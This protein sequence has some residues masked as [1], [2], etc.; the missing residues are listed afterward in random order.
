[1]SKKFEVVIVGG[2]TAGLSVAARLRNA[3]NPPEVAII[4]PSDKHYYQ[5][6]WTL[7]GAGVFPREITE[8]EEADYIP[9]GATWIRDAVASFDPEQNALTTKKG[10]VIQYDYLVVAAGIQLNWDK[11]D[12]LKEALGKNGVCSN[13]SYATVESTWETIRGF[14]GGKALFTFPATPIKCAG[15]PQKIMYLAEHAF[16]RQ[17]VRADS[18]LVYCC[19]GP[20][21]FGVAK[22][23]D[24]LEKVVADRDIKTAFRHNLEAIRADKKQAVFRDL[25]KDEQVVMDYEMIHV[26]PPQGAPAFIA[27]SKLASE[28]GWVEVD[29]HSL[30]HVRY[31]NVFSLGDC[32]SLPCSKTGAAIRKQSPVMVQ[33][34]LAV[35]AHK[36]ANASYD[37]YASC[38]LITGYGTCILA[39]FNYDGEP[40]E[41][42]DF[43]QAEE[44]YS[45]YA[46]KAYALPKIYWHGM[47]RGRM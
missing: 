28:A 31:K 15:A 35:R 13:Y 36:A 44:R 1:M 47:L 25:D 5:P 19:A 43:N 11:I 34:L 9:A 42:F 27:Q 12:G 32:S 17:G 18:E 3:P 26:T 6:L 20:R 22:Y 23:R 8:R 45:M 24:A 10:E 46:L 30:Q 21:I 29:K 39:E 37:G 16:R 4:E 33:N 14:K 41:T 40:T 38:P 7:V 2:G